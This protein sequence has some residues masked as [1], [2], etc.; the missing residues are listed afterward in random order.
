MSQ[1]Q[2]ISTCL[3]YDT[4][5][6]EAASFYVSL[7]DNSR[8]VNVNRRPTDGP[9]AE[10]KVL[11]VNF[12]LD[13]TAYIALNGGPHYTFTEATSIFVKCDSQEEVDRLW[14]A[15]LVDGGQ[16]SKCGWLKDRYGLSWQIIPRAMFQLFDDKARAPRVMAAMMEMVKLDIAKLEAAYNGD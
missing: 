10:G 8:I 3:W 7:F 9:S 5:A 12:E 1:S 15:L 6:E 4:Q 16:E 13:G 2:K 14:D 11:T